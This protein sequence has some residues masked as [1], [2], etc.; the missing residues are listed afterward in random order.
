[1]DYKR[2]NFEANEDGVTVCKD[3]HDK[4]QPCEYEELSSYEVVEIINNMRSKLIR[5]ELALN[6]LKTLEI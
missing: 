2:W 3:E 4:G 1:M 5:A 6:Q